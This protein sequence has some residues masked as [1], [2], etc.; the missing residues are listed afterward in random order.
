MKN[1]QSL[2]IVLIDD[3]EIA[4]R[5]IA[6]ALEL[7]G[8]QIEQFQDV[9]QFLEEFHIG[10][11]DILITDYRMP[12]INGLELIEH[13]Q[14]IDPQLQPIIYTGYPENNLI[15]SFQARGLCWFSKPFSIKDLIKQ[16]EKTSTFKKEERCIS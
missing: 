12:H 8:Y 1:K 6:S 4:L 16:I 2:A 3:N 5:S 15:R 7:Y 13:M 11:Y 14:F 9:L 10:K